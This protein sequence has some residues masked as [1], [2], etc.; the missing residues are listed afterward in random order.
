MS[1]PPVVIDTNVFPFKDMV[2]W[3]G[4]YRGDKI[5]PS[6]VYMELAVWY[7]AKDG[8]LAKLEAMLRSAAIEIRDFDAH[9]AQSSAY[10]I[11][12]HRIPKDKWKDA[13]IASFAANPPFILLTNNIRDFSPML[14][15]RAIPPYDFKKAMLEGNLYEFLDADESGSD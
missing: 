2:H 15:K 10:F 11:K 7:Y 12:E 5:I 13:M 14:G 3:L 6:V 1:N 4:S 8:N 9:H